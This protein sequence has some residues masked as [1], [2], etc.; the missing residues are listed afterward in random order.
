[1]TNAAFLLSGQRQPPGRPG[2]SSG[3]SKAASPSRGCDVAAAAAAAASGSAAPQPNDLAPST[4]TFIRKLYQ[5][6]TMEDQEVI[7]FTSGAYDRRLCRLA[8]V[9][10]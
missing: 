6:V 9:C 8:G 2:A 3:G 5:M 1:M 10:V 4:N 7:A